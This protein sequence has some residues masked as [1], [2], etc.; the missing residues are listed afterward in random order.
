MI[1]CDGWKL[2]Y[3][4]EGQGIP[5]LVIGSSL[6][7]PRSFSQNLRRHLQ[8][9]F[10]DW[11]GFAAPPAAP[12]APSF[13][14][15]LD[16]VEQIRKAAGHQRVVVIGHSAHALM[17]LEYAKRYPEA[18]SHV[19]MIGSSPDL[20]LANAEAAQR[21]WE[22][23]VWPERK[24]ALEERAHNLTG[25]SRS[26]AFVQWYIQRDPQ[27]WYDYRFNSASLWEGVKPNMEMFDYLYGTVLR[28]IDIVKGLESF[29][30][31]VFLALGRYDFIVAP[32]S[33]WDGVRPK[34]RNLTVRVFEHSGHSPQFEEPTLFD[35]ELLGWLA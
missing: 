30:R 26:D 31:P 28:D 9:I 4:V 11:R 16:D 22:E 32:P 20:G 2:N 34:F 33:S 21:N 7:Y 12:Q 1:E 19:V 10:A 25:L 13:T 35:Q 8:L 18:V 15:L 23:S 3:R 14:A 17:A 27:A 6:F 29:D 24:K 5:A